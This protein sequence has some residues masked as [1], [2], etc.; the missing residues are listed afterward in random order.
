MPFASCAINEKSIAVYHGHHEPCQP[1]A[2]LCR[3]HKTRSEATWISTSSLTPL[4]RGIGYTRQQ[5]QA[6]THQTP[7]GRSA[8]STPIKKINNDKQFHIIGRETDLVSK[9]G[10]HAFYNHSSLVV[11]SSLPL[12]LLLICNGRSTKHVIYCL[13]VLVWTRGLTPGHHQIARPAPCL[14]PVAPKS[15]SLADT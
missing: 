15:P 7:R 13:H 9:H 3:F 6:A 1:G 12:L 2:R 5:Q 14:L 4:M 10:M 11:V 8:N